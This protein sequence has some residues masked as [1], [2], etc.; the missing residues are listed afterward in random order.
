MECTFNVDPEPPAI[1]SNFE[2]ISTESKIELSWS[3]N[4]EPDFDGYNLYKSNESIDDIQQVN[5][6]HE[7]LYTD[8]LFIDE[9]VSNGT[10]YYY[11]ITSVD[12]NGNESDLSREIKI[13]PF[14]P[15]PTRP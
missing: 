13:T 10:T 2:G 6:V 3:F 8:S 14:T 9:Q 15:P 5:P 12:L 7:S 4:R 1:P 11:R